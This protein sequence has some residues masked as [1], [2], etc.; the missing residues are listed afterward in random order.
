MRNE[1]YFLIVNLFQ[2]KSRIKK[3]ANNPQFRDLSFICGVNLKSLARTRFLWGKT[4]FC[5]F[6]TTGHFCNNS[7][8]NPRSETTTE[9]KTAFSNLFEDRYSIEPGLLDSVFCFRWLLLLSCFP[10]TFPWFFF[11]RVWSM[12][13]H[14][15]CIYSYN[16]KNASGL[17]FHD[18]KQHVWLRRTLQSNSIAFCVLIE[19]TPYK[20]VTMSIITI[21]DL[22]SKNS[23]S[24]WCMLF[25]WRILS[26]WAITSAIHRYINT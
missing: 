15:K 3:W 9:C 20:W 23:Q 18:L 8:K 1:P 16:P 17:S 4:S 26:L 21:S 25:S 11:P 12:V 19:L 6:C 10:D 5:D 7:P 22:K 2:P 14:T 13:S 24:I